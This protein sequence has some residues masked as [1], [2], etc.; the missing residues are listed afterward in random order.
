MK[1][2]LDSSGAAGAR[3]RCAAH[4]GRGGGDDSSTTDNDELGGSS[5]LVY[6]VGGLDDAASAAAPPV[7]IEA[8]DDACIILPCPASA[9]ETTP[10][11]TSLNVAE[12]IRL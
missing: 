10:V 7:A 2:A 1:I 11:P 5:A 6:P 4:G 12:R 3:S 9:I 8:R